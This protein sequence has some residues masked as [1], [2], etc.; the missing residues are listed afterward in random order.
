MTLK[1]PAGVFLAMVCQRFRLADGDFLAFVDGDTI[2]DLQGD[3]LDGFRGRLEIDAEDEDRDIMVLFEPMGSAEGFKS[4]NEA[5]DAVGD[6]Y[7][8]T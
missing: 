1:V 4:S 2:E 8:K 6:G 5:I 7:V 3:D